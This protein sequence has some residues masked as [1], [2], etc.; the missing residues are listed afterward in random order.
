MK[1]SYH[2]VLVGAG[3]F[4][5]TFAYLARQRG[6]RVLI[7][8]RRPHIAGNVYT[9]VQDGITVHKY[10]AHIFHTSS[11]AI[12]DFV[13]QFAE[14]NHYV[15][16]PVANYQGRL[17][18]LPFNM[19]TFY[20]LWGCRTPKE[21][22]QKLEEQRSCEELH[23]A[24]ANLKE[25]ALQLVGRDIYEKLIEGYTEK[26]WGRPCT[27]L[28]PSIIRRLPF[29]FTFD[30]NYFKDPFQGIP[31]SGGYSAICAQLAASAELALGTDFLH[32]RKRLE[33]L[34]QRIIYTGMI[35]EYFDYCE[36]QLDYRSLYFQTKT[37]QTDNFQGNAVVNYT[38][39]EIPYTRI[40]E[41]KHFDVGSKAIDLPQ[42]VVTWEY[43]Q[44]F[45]PGKEPFYPVNNEANLQLLQKYQ[46]RAEAQRAARQVYFAG[47]LGSYKYFD[48]DQVIGEAMALF[49][50]L[51][52]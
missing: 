20:Q 38:D 33:G 45:G 37:L 13:R 8:D 12:W 14:F 52:G 43:P 1:H 48:M 17:Y 44:A 24:P 5:C 40:I 42:T 50:K 18:N 31:R 23:R 6:L 4:S 32:E 34:A 10:G 41:H 11:K 36:G 2:Y 7:V 19:N 26:Q 3:F 46:K 25:Q 51:E 16:S 47:R 27:E 9:E 21:A 29:R 39:S 30:N 22:R 15:N 49:A 28:P 35:D